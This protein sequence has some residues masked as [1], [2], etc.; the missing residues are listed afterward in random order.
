MQ[1]RFNNF[2]ARVHVP[3]L[4]KFEK[5]RAIS[6]IRSGKRSA[7]NAPISRM[8]IPS[9]FVSLRPEVLADSMC[10][11]STLHR[12]VEP[13]AAQ[14]FAFNNR[15]IVGFARYERATWRVT[16][17][18]HSSKIVDNLSRIDGNFPSY[19]YAIK[20]GAIFSR[21]RCPS[22]SLAATRLIL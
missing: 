21:L 10:N 5:R 3:E 2:L 12:G 16:S 18:R 19:V 1:H 6:E 15:Q 17:R 14:G 11:G 22:R 9:S 4:M 20:R 13:R 8:R 7:V